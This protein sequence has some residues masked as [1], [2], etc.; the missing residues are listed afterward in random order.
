[1]KKN[2]YFDVLIIKD[3]L[4]SVD[5]IQVMMKDKCCGVFHEND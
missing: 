5:M 4:D 2:N 3:E 1:M